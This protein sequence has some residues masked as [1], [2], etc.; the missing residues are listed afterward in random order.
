MTDSLDNLAERLA[1]RFND[2][3]LLDEAVTHRSVSERNNERLE[4]LGDSILNFVIA[5]ELFHRQPRESEGAL[6]RLRA[7]L[8]NRETLAAI[9][10]QLD[11]GGHLRLGSGERK[12]GGRRRDSILSDALEGVLGAVY[13]DGGFDACRT[14]I[15]RLFAE[16]LE[17][18]PDAADLKDPKTRLQEYLQSARLDLPSYHVLEVAGKAHDQL[19]RVECRI[20][21]ID[22]VTV[23]EAGSRRR[24]EQRGAEAMLNL[25]QP[26]N[27]GER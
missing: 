24:A 2:R 27:R 6:S 17:H 18:L 16:R 26:A 25:L 23:G 10:R 22:Q 19:F 1:Y 14:L 8:V 3:A 21:G 13:L 12:S 20:R 15:V 5:D 11:L 4:F 7:S 9:A